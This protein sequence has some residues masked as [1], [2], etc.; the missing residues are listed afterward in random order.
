MGVVVSRT[1]PRLDKIELTNR[2][3]MREIGLLV[4]ETILTR[5][6]S[7]RNAKG[8]KF[9]A[10]SE[11]YAARR[12]KEGLSTSVNLAVSGGMLRDLKVVV[13]DD[14]TVTVGY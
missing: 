14:H 4:R 3:L 10:Y 6:A 9:Q 7:G 8:H 11:G 1:I 2:E 5:T 13:G 12:A